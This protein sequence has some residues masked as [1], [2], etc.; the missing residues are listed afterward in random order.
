MTA[1]RPPALKPT[2]SSRVP[3]SW[4]AMA[5]PACVHS[6]GTDVAPPQLREE[7]ERC[8]AAARW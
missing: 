6:T 7:A 1:A 3:A 5:G 2:Q 8:E 4:L